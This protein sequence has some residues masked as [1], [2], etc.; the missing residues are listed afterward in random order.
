MEYMTTLTYAHT[1]TNVNKVNR[2]KMVKDLGIKL[3]L[4][5]EQ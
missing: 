4:R 2:I 3:F 5:N 1:R